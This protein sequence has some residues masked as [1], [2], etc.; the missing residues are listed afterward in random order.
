MER[1]RR[2]TPRDKHGSH[3]VD[4]SEFGLDPERLRER[5]AFYSARFPGVLA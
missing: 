5:F 4:V 1:W 3:S 2:S